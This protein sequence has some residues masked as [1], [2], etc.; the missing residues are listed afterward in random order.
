MLSV[1]DSV[2][3]LGS[4]VGLAIGFIGKKFRVQVDSTLLSK[5]HD[6]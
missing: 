2:D 1:M 3:C 4:L 6:K 5:T